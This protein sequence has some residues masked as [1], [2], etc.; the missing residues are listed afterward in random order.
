M[1]R[2]AVITPARRLA[3]P[4]AQVDL[5]D[6]QGL[7]VRGYGRLPHATYLLTAIAEGANLGA[8]L[9][10]WA[11][12]VSTG[13]PIRADTALNV[14][15]T[16]TG[17]VAAGLPQEVV[18]GGFASPFVEGM[19]TEHRS[20]ILG[21][22][23]PAEPRRWSWGGPNNPPVHVLL[24][25]YATT[26]ETLD[27]RLAAL[28]EEAAGALR[29]V[30]ELPTEPLS[31]IEPFGFADGLSQP[32]PAGLPSPTGG[33]TVATGEFVL[34]YPN[35]YGQLTERPLLDPTTDP[36]RILQR[37]A[38][39]TGAAD[40]RRNGSY[41]VLRQLRQDV[42]GFRAFLADR[43]RR[44]D[45]AED[46]VAQARLGAM[47]V[48]RWPSGAPVA[49]TPDQD[50]PE[51]ASAE[52]G[53]H[54]I[55]RDGLRCPLGAHIRRANPRDSLEP[56]PGTDRSLASTDRHRLLRRGRSYSLDDGERGL[57]FLCLVANIARQ[58]EFV[59]HSWI[60]SP[61]FNGLQDQPDPLVGSRS[62]AATFVEPTLPVRRR[63]AG[64]PEFVRMCGGGYFFLPG[65]SA[66][67]YLGQVPR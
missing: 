61:V 35:G 47:I 23:G 10:R 28:R 59:Q 18:E 41:L 3:L 7:I 26:P 12:E 21:D 51:L 45:G 1:A 37:D 31:P 33:R 63:H 43:T 53:Y 5:G 48:G 39:G 50:D 29:I 17:L 34:G 19:V 2:A 42:A 16:A 36:R 6:V 24:L 44:R 57:Y 65:V 60:N 25:V 22:V 8:L 52:F 49:L 30:A 58:Y 56:H 40:L 38:G 54:N 15:F 55:D 64:L 11:D 14:A 66:L 20:R 46:P 27:A 4:D 62:G 32:R 9:G 67:R 13:E